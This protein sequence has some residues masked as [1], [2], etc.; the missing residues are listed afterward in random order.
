MEQ[1]EQIK[2]KTQDMEGEKYLVV[3]DLVTRYF[4]SK[5]IV[6]AIDGVVYFTQLF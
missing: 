5:G 6:K 2:E 4:T 1:Q 3:E